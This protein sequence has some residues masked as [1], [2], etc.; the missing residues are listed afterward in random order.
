MPNHPSQKR[1]TCMVGTRPEVLKM[2]PV[3]AAMRAIGLSVQVVNSGQQ[4]SLTG[5]ALCNVGLEADAT[6]LLTRKDSSLNALTSELMSAT[7]AYLNENPCAILMVHGDT[8]TAFSAGM[9][10][11]HLGIPIAHIEAGL[12]SQSMSDPFP[13]EAYR[14]LLGPLSQWHFAPT[15]RAR[16]Q[17][18][19]E[20]VRGEIH[21]TGNT[22]IDGLL[23]TA[24]ALAQGTRQVSPNIQAL[25]Q[26][27]G[28]RNLLV[29][30]HRRENWGE[31]LENVTRALH[32]WLR[33][34]PD[35]QVVWPLHPNPELRK[36]NHMQFEVLSNG[37]L[38]PNL[39]L[40]EPID[41]ADL[42][43][44][45]QQVFAIATDSGGLQEEASAFQTPVLILRDTTERPEAVEAGYA[46]L[47]GCEYEAVLNALTLAAQK[48]PHGNGL[49]TNKVLWPFGDGKASERI[50]ALLKRSLNALE[51][52]CVGCALLLLQPNE[53]TAQDNLNISNAATNKF[54]VAFSGGSATQGFQEGV[55][56]AL[57]LAHT[58]TDSDLNAELV[59]QSRFNLQGTQVGVGLNKKISNDNR[60]LLSAS[61]GESRLYAKYG[62]Q[63]GLAHT[64]K[65]APQWVTQVGVSHQ[66]LR[67]NREQNALILE[68]SW[69]TPWGGTLQ[70]GVRQGISKPGS[71]GF[72][73]AHIAATWNI[74]DIQVF[75]RR[76][77]A[78][79]A[80]QAIDASAFIVDFK[81][82]TTQLGLNIPLSKTQRLGIQGNRYE[83]PFY[84]RNVIQT[85]WGSTW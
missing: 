1:I 14:T 26:K 69:Y 61:A 54:S 57:K 80:Y 85:Q 56:V 75:A 38:P 53:S 6:L 72:N 65:N 7:A 55:G 50:A 2:A 32:E 25:F 79:E 46:Q 43:W 28:K 8:A 81:S 44:S 66:S 58:T 21:V 70:A 31:P 68:Q 20:N 60:L 30:L 42:V 64:W 29:T 45:M 3:V 22:C 67:D 13:E 15:P 83:T 84:R 71:V 62:A 19:R 48:N 36:K 40:I 59:R 39:Q 17:L 12:R 76:E 35:H 63:I 52:A 27:Y 34:H 74:G 11:F 73:S 49:K 23:N 9:V 16:D 82:D 41:Y 33:K 18:M 51:M 10:A 78:H 37:E 5:Q 4:S 47:V 24:E 77:S